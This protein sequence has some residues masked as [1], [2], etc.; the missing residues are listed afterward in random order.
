MGGCGVLGVTA[1]QAAAVAGY[2][3]MGWIVGGMEVLGAVGVLS[4]I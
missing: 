2:G 1:Q 4:G 3:V